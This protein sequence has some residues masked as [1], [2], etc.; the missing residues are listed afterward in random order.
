MRDELVFIEIKSL[1][2]TIV[3]YIARKT[4]EFIKYLKRDFELVCLIMIICVMKL[5]KIKHLPFNLN[6]TSSTKFGYF[7]RSNILQTSKQV[8]VNYH[9]FLIITRMFKVD[10][11]FKKVRV[12]F[13]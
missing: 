12:N 2:E 10:R 11:Y 6:R 5:I 8:Y 7:A 4:F 1:I 3:E 13:F 9:K